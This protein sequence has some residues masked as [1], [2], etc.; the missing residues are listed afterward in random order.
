VTGITGR[1][2]D[3]RVAE[4]PAPSVLFRGCGR[5]AKPSR[6]R[7]S[8]DN[9]TARYGFTRLIHQ[10]MI[11]EKVAVPAMVAVQEQETNEQKQGCVQLSTQA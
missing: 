3:A 9:K 8:V 2:L 6:D 10:E 4:F 1:E 7:R 5:A 11:A